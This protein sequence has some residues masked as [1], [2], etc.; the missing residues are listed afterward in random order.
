MRAG[1]EQGGETHKAILDVL[2]HKPYSL[3]SIFV[4]LGDQDQC[5]AQ[6]EVKAFIDKTHLDISA[7][8]YGHFKFSGTLKSQLR[9]RSTAFEAKGDHEKASMKKLYD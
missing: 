3:V 9:E 1:K 8:E 7:Y 4:V 6:S 2:A 5:I